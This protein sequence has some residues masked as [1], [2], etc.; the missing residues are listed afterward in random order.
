MSGLSHTRADPPSIAELEHDRSRRERLGP[1]VS[2]IEERETEERIRQGYLPSPE[3]ESVTRQIAGPS[4]TSRHSGQRYHLGQGAS[5]I[6][7]A[8]SF[9]AR[10]SGSAGNQDGTSTWSAEANRQIDPHPQSPQNVL[11][12]STS[13][14]V[15]PP[16]NTVDPAKYSSPE[17]LRRLAEEDTKRRMQETGES[18]LP[19]TSSPSP[20]T[21][22]N[23][24][25][26]PRR[27]G[28]G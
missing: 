13:P 4:G 20:T 8:P 5:R 26:K 22:S 17:E 9:V 6:N 19:T 23:P 1:L 16:P 7:A 14:G 15:A 21:P 11:P 10:P 27:R 24:T 28:A 18:P 2:A 12:T 3:A 25:F